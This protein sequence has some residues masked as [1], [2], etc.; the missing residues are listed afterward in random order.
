MIHREA[1]PILYSENH[2]IIPSIHLKAFLHIIRFSTRHLANI[3]FELNDLAY[4][5]DRD[6]RWHNAFVLLQRLNGLREL[7]V[8]LYVHADY[9][10]HELMAREL[11]PIVANMKEAR[12]MEKMAWTGKSL[13][14]AL[15]FSV[16]VKPANTRWLR[17]P[18]KAE[19][20]TL[21][22]NFGLDVLALLGQDICQ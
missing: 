15:T 4:S 9:L 16:Q 14:E 19:R 7:K 17:H 1:R 5:G 20:E 12:L 11:L 21:A 22:Q 6:K 2:F 8:R 13:A 18:L 10:D 3:T